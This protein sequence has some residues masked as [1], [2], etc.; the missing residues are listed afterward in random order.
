VAIHIGCA[1]WSIPGRLKDCFP[2]NGTHLERYA[3]RFNAVEINS[4]FYRSH[5]QK[6]YVRWAAATPPDFRF[7]VKTPRHI[8]HT[9][10]LVG[11]EEPLKQFLKEVAG[12]G[13]KLGAILVQLPPSLAFF[14]GAQ[15]FLDNLRSLTS[16]AVVLEPRH[17]SWFEAGV[18]RLLIDHQ[19]SRVAADPPPV[20]AASLPAG[21]PGTIYYRLHGSPRVY[22]STY[23]AQ[24]LDQSAEAL[25]RP[26]M[27]TESGW[28]I[29][30]NTALGGAYENGLSLLQKLGF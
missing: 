25:R 29:F 10:R 23:D 22:Y 7:S 5:Q 15:D 11:A 16:T 30:D 20:P 4:C 27:A 21:Y 13:D 19:I 9:L 28:C 18:E 2:G 1:G 24:F 12:L 17:S 8:T 14:D 6:T 26:A 3:A